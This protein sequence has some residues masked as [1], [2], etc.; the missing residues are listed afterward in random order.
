MIVP[1]IDVKIDSPTETGEGEILVKGPNLTQGYFKRQEL[2][3]EMF[4][5]DGWFKTGD[6]GMFVKGRFLKITDRKKDIFKTSAG[7]YIAPQP[8]QNHFNK[9]PFIQRCLIIG[10]QK[11]FVTALL[12]PHFEILQAWCLQEGIHWTFLNL[13]FIIL[14]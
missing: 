3:N 5:T 9:S 6:V 11:P 10:F 8:L 14:K 4:T 13:W 2:T 1:G 7:K 12:V